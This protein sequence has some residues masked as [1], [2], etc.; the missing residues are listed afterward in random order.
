L[1]KSLTYK[2]FKLL[3]SLVIIIVAIK[4][5]KLDTNEKV[6]NILARYNFDQEYY[7]TQYPE[8]KL[9]D[10]SPF[11]HYVS[12]GW[13]EDKNPN[14]HFNTR[15]YRNLYLTEMNKHDLNPLA[16]YTRAAIVFKKRYAHKKE[17]K[18]TTLLDNQKYYLTLTAI[19]Q[20]EDRFLKEWIEFY[21]MLGV[22]HF[23]LFNHNSTDQYYN[24]L[25]PYIKKGIVEL[26]TVTE[27]PTNPSHWNK[28]QTS[29]YQKAINKAKQLTE[30]MILVDTDEF[31]FPVKDGDL[32]TTL[33]RYDEYASISVN[34]KIYGTSGVEKIQSNE[35][36]IQKL[37]KSNPHQDLH[38]KTILKPRYVK[39]M[40][41]PHYAYLLPGYMQ[42]DE[43]FEFFKGPFMP[44]ETRNILRINHYWSRDNDFFQKNKIQR[45]HISGGSISKEQKKKK[46]EGFVKYNNS[47]K[48]ETNNPIEKYFN[49]MQI[50][51]FPNQNTGTIPQIH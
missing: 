38:V 8:V 37:T 4:A 16:E 33:K 9:S 7:L 19:F 49:K 27:I 45:V 32:I 26:E 12:I 46:I 42:V 50:R 43:K 22:E 51:M 10:L 21:L 28:I 34:W 39:I 36:M 25:E 23:Y 35:L 5:L 2:L 40:T 13:K 44:Y 18:K 47:L 11:E 24:V 29:V 17:L 15:L 20:N 31:L 30:W 48:K 41:N 3:F 6:L 14:V 1:I